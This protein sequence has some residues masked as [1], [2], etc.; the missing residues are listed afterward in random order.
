M[1]LNAIDGEIIA[2]RGLAHIDVGVREVGFVVAP[3]EK[4]IVALEQS[5]VV[6]LLCWSGLG[7]RRCLSGRVGVGS[8]RLRPSGQQQQG[9]DEGEFCH[10]VF[11][12]NIY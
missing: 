11:S 5:T 3:R 7:C 8:L 2:K 12:V 4:P 9:Q 1:A 6:R 10:F